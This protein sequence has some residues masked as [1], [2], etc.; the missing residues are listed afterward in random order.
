MI[1]KLADLLN[2]PISGEAELAV[3]AY[4]AG[5]KAVIE[6]IEEHRDIEE[7]RYPQGD[8]VSPITISR[9]LWRQL[10]QEMLGDE[11]RCVS[12]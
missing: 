4:K 11:E 2:H 7:F 6:W 3:K 12:L 5:K 8:Q 9:S 1:D 10:C